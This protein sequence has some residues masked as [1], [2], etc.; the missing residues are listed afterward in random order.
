V[1]PPLPRRRA[2]GD[3]AG[4][5]ETL[6]KPSPLDDKPAVRR[7][8]ALVLA[9]A[10]LVAALGYA[11]F[12]WI[13]YED[14]TAA[15]LHFGAPEASDDGTRQLGVYVTVLTIDPVNEAVHL[16]LHVTP[17]RALRGPRPNTLASSLVLRVDDGS[18]A[19]EQAFHANEP[20]APVNVEASLEGS[21]AAAYPLE[22]FHVALRFAAREEGAAAAVPLRLTLW[23]GI[24]GWSVRASEQPAEAGEIRL[25]LTVRRIGAI[26]FLVI[27]L[28]GTMAMIA[29]AALT[30]GG[31]V[32]LHYR[33]LEATLAGFL[34]G[35]L[36]ALPALRYA[37]PG[38]PPPGVLAD[39][40]VFLW[41]E[42][43]VALGLL[44]F[45]LT[46]AMD[47]KRD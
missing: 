4:V 16:R 10:M 45:V 13:S 15:E 29:G 44:L 20:I 34:S 11:A 22:R 17:S 9:C 37:L 39:H 6:Q 31:L 14:M 42:L 40:L 36:F 28:Y 35:M 26:A 2:A 3:D 23:E 8:R 12:F 32:F 5:S 47:G 38:S 18:S 24:A 1:R 7:R 25:L 46:W 43:A 19:H 27:A 21:S 41:A 33:R 30:I